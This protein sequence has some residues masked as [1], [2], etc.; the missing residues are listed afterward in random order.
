MKKVFEEPTLKVIRF[1]VTESL[2]S[3]AEAGWSYNVD[4]DAGVGEW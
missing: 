3:N 4:Y 2:T 1:E